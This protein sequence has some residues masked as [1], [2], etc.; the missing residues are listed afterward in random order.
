M[1]DIEEEL[2]N[3]ISKADSKDNSWKTTENKDGDMVFTTSDRRITNLEDV[4]KVANI[5]T[6]IYE[7]VQQECSAWDVAGKFGKE[8]DYEWNTRQNYR[9][10]ARFKR[11]IPVYAEKYFEHFIERMKGHELNFP[12]LKR[13][14]PEDPFMGVASFPDAHI[15]MYAWAQEAGEDYNT[16]IGCRLFNHVGRELIG[17]CAGYNLDKIVITVGSDMFH[18]NDINAVTPKGKNMLDVDSRLP[19]VFDGVVD[20]YIDL[21]AYLRKYADIDVV[22]VPGNHDPISSW[23][24]AKYLYGVYKYVNDVS[25]DCSF[26]PRKKIVYGTNLVGFTHGSEEKENQLP[27]IMAT[28]WR[29]D[30]GNTKHHVWFKGHI[31]Q[32]KK[33]ITT[34]VNEHEGVQIITLPSLCAKDAWTNMK[35][36]FSIRSADLHLFSKDHGPA[37]YFS[38]NVEDNDIWRRKE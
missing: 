9:F 34:S 27:N 33:T 10:Y 5:D 29:K 12:K 15:G 24:L 6:S 18:A 36:Y 25:V 20:A 13:V 17:R 26:N 7:C 30:W 32:R 14:V 35:G 1:T 38:V 23:Y 22:W 4:I 31:H 19:K 37:G 11:V 8:G 28:E 2:D 21:I 16:D 3:A